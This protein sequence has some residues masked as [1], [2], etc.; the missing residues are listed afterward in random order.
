MS[1]T[2]FSQTAFESRKK[3]AIELQ[4][5]RFTTSLSDIE[6][7]SDNRIKIKGIDQSIGLTSVAMKQ[8]ARS[9]GVSMAF[10]DKVGH[11]FGDETGISM[12]NRI[13][14]AQAA[15]E[16][17]YI[18]LLASVPDKK[19]IAV[20]KEYTDVISNGF[21]FDI[22][23][24]VLADHNMKVVDF[25]VDKDGRT[26]ISACNPKNAFK[27]LNLD[28][29]IF[30]GGV[31]FYNSPEKGF[32][33][34]PYVNRLICTNGSELEEFQ[35]SVKMRTFTGE[36]LEAFFK[37]MAGFSN[38]GFQPTGLGERMEL[39]MNSN[40]SVGEIEYAAS[41]LNSKTGMDKTEIEIYSPV[42]SIHESYSASG[43][44]PSSLSKDQKKE[45]SD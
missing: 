37:K 30:R 18:T 26:S 21:F 10:Q 3:R 6:I 24:K 1:L 25:S 40:A 43:I 23:E 12:V 33:V 42:K 17:K 41:L 7:L 15:S 31:N 27:M 13:R 39:A 2:T 5:K 19:V 14:M 9:V 36:D 8:L 35:D 4:P 45:C 11:L 44:S 28:S 38:R 22:V 16:D 34:S 32:S 20:N 29:E